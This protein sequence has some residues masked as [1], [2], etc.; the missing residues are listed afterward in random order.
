[1]NAVE[2][3]EI[4]RGTQM[5]AAAAAA[6]TGG[7]RGG[8]KGAEARRVSP[9][10]AGAGAG[11]LT[12]VLKPLAVFFVPYVSCRQ[13]GGGCAIAVSDDGRY[14]FSGC[15]RSV[16]WMGVHFAPKTKK[17]CFRPTRSSGIPFQH[18]FVTPGVLRV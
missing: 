10:G 17:S 8:G 13:F 14:V 16:A 4:A 12:G 7:G 11:A 2:G 3:G 5:A 6:R 15:C 1:M 9:A 18:P